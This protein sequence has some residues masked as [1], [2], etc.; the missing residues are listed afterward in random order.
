MVVDFRYLAWLSLVSYS[1]TFAHIESTSPIFKGTRWIAKT[2]NYSL[3]GC[4][5][6]VGF[7][8]SVAVYFLLFGHGHDPATGTTVRTALVY[9][10]SSAML[11]VLYDKVVTILWKVG[12]DA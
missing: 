7:W 9:I 6:C 1:L 4:Y 5:H 12:Q 11:C 2:V 3:V 10:L 8:V